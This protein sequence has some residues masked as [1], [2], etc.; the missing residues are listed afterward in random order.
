MFRGL[1]RRASSRRRRACRSGWW[2]AL[3]LCPSPLGMRCCVVAPFLSSEKLSPNVM[4]GDST[5]HSSAPHGEIAMATV[6][7]IDAGVVPSGTDSV[8]TVA[9][10]V[11][12]TTVFSLAP[13]IDSGVDPSAID[14]L[15]FCKICMICPIQ[16]SHRAKCL[17]L[18][19]L[20][21]KLCIC[22]QNQRRPSLLGRRETFSYHH[23]DFKSR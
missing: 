3:T 19:S 9:S 15:L 6:S 5:S 4:D 23:Q 17:L 7:G 1:A 10:V 20:S 12:D 22:F 8:M 13:R 18:G 2:R 11:G 21:S 16:T 14:S